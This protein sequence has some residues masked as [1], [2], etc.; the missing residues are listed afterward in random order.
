MG[1]TIFDQMAAGQ[2]PGGDAPPPAAPPAAAAPPRAGGGTI[3]DQM[4]A[5]QTSTTGAAGPGGTGTGTMQ[6]VKPVPQ[7]LPEQILDTMGGMGGPE[8]YTTRTVAGMIRGGIG[9][10]ASLGDLAVR[11]VT[12]EAPDERH[13]RFLD[14]MKAIAE[15]GS[16]PDEKAGK[17]MEGLAEFATGD[18]ALKELSYAERLQKVLPFLKTVEGDTSLMNAL[19]RGIVAGTEGATVG[20]GVTT[21]QTGDPVKGL[22]GAA[23]GGTLGAVPELPGV[24]RAAGR[25]GRELWT[26]ATAQQ[27][28]QEDLM[29]GIRGILK[30]AAG[31]RNVPL[32]DDI[33]SIRDV[34]E[35]LSNALRQPAAVGQTTAEAAAEAQNNLQKGIRDV[36][37]KSGEDMNLKVEEPQSIR[38]AALKLSDSLE[39]KA[40]GTYQQL[41]EALGGR[42]F[43]TYSEKIKNINNALRNVTGT[44]PEEE[45]RLVERLNAEQASME[46]A[47]KELRG[48]GLDPDLIKEANNLYRQHKGVEEL[49]NH[50]RKTTQGL[51]P[52][53]RQAGEPATPET[54][55]PGRLEARVNAMY[56]SGRLQSALGEG[57]AQD[58]LRHVDRA[59]VATPKTPEALRQQSDALDELTAVIR[60]NTDGMRPQ[61]VTPG[62]VG[63]PESLKIQQLFDHLHDM[64]DDER[65][66]EALGP[67]R[68]R[69]LLNEVDAAK[70]QSDN[71]VRRT[72]R[73]KTGVKV[74]AGLTGVGLAAG[75]RT[76]EHLLEGRYYNR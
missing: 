22:E 4:A 62:R 71:I 52:E 27:G 76:A 41:D 42:R 31:D 51:R 39:D 57:H 58:L 15:G 43:Q 45:G 30:G 75:Y 5:G 74:G 47:I 23:I 29:Q 3:F 48:K 44:D 46:Q 10:A 61:D 54:V 16:T 69:D 2:A 14:R 18:A 12:G 56:D 40:K 20:G 36:I 28:V 35:H 65:L 53:L 60:N 33:P 7:G 19:R 13:F 55:H 17:V 26:G 66:Q 34:S 11:G 38:D 25:T 24:V 9:T 59:Q 67:G 50:I 68:A 21:A 70:I 8:G 1:T 6:P 37:R 73:I 32:P 72:N 49:S 63:T 64:H